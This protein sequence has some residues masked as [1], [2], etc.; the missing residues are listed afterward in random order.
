MTSIFENLFNKSAIKSL[1][2]SQLNEY[3]KQYPDYKSYYLEVGLY[4][5]LYDYAHIKV[6]LKDSGGNSL[7]DFNLLSNKFAENLEP[8]KSLKLF[9]AENKIEKLP[10][11]QALV[12][13]QPESVVA[14]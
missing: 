13:Y 7:G 10:E 9:I 3:L 6:T 5:G 4:Y 14:E 2:N 8:V 11:Y 12:F 1:V